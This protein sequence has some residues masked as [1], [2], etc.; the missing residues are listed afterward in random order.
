MVGLSVRYFDTSLAV[1]TAHFASDSK[2]RNRV[3]KRNK[4]RKRGREGGR[5][6]RREGE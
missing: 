5:E 3:T 4:V 1:I 2:G 6:G